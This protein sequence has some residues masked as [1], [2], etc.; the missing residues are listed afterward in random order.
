MPEAVAVP[1]QFREAIDF[2]K[3]KVRLPSNTWT[4]LWQEQHGLGFVVAGATKAALVADFQNAIAK[5]LEEGTTLEDFRSD[6]DQIVARHGWT[7]KG[8]RGWRS[9][10]IY[11]TNLRMAKAAGRWAQIERVK[12]LRPFLRYVTVGDERVRRSHKTWHGLVY[13]VDHP[14]WDSHYPPNGWGCRCDVQSLSARDV[15]KLGY[16]ISTALPAD[17]M[18]S[19]TIRRGGKDVAVS[20]P[21]GI[22]PGF[23]YNPGRNRLTGL[24]PPPAGGDPAPG[25][26]AG[27]PSPMPSRRAFDP[28]LLLPEKGLKEE[29]YARAFLKEFK[30]DIGKPVSFIDKAGEALPISEALFKDVT[31]EWKITKSG[32]HPFMRLLAH[33]IMDP[34]EIW[35]DWY[36][37]KNGVYQLRRRYLSRFDLGADQQSGFAVFEVTPSGWREVTNFAPKNDKSAAAQDAYLDKQRRGYRVYVRK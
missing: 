7:Y 17:G 36:R 18:A 37:E 8:K 33:S 26:G 30:A 13:P 22:D 21:K 5:A 1:V 28:K 20:V 27:P 31:G 25:I 9:R 6:F 35:F 29:A 34:D 4:D 2:F 3:A 14:F 16:S 32:R 24:S 15:K 12:K 19:H 11:E 23:A 10:V